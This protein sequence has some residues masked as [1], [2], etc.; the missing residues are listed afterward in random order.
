MAESLQTD[1]RISSRMSRGYG[2]NP[3][4]RNDGQSVLSVRSRGTRNPVVRPVVSSFSAPAAP[5]GAERATRTAAPAGA[6]RSFGIETYRRNQEWTSEQRTAVS[7]TASL[8]ALTTPRATFSPR[9]LTG[10]NTSQAGSSTSGFFIESLGS[11]MNEA[12]GRYRD[13]ESGTAT[14]RGSFSVIADI[15]RRIDTLSLAGIS[16]LA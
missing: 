11:V 9:L 2:S 7:N 8:L 14:S 1:Y 4:L 16:L 6:T 3:F 5:S 10:L 15:Y 13:I 12:I